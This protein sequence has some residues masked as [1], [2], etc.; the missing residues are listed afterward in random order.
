VD[1]AGDQTGKGLAQ[2]CD[3]GLGGL[4]LAVG[5]DAGTQLGMRTPHAVL[6]L[7]GI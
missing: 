3:R 1:K 2:I 7:L 5:T 6:V 4:A